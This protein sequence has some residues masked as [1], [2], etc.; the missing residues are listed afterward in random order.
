MKLFF[1]VLAYQTTASLSIW[2]A[3]QLC[4]KDIEGWGWFI[5]IALVVATVNIKLSSKD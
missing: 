1:T 3:Y 2:C 4:S 5:F